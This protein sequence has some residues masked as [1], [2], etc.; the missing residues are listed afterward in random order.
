MEL[1]QAVMKRIRPVVLAAA[2]SAAL[3]TLAPAGAGAAES[4]V[5]LIVHKSNPL[6]NLTSAELRRIFLG[7]QTRWPSKAEITIL[8]P[9]PGNE[10]RKFF[11]DSL[12]KMSDDDYIRYWVSRVM[13]GEAT[14]GPRPLSPASMAR[15]VAGL[16]AAI[17]VI[18]MAD[19]PIE[20]TDLKIL[21]IDG[22]APGERG[23]RFRRKAR[24]AR[25]GK[26]V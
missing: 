6:N 23:Y 16:P 4:D 10:E 9:P 7:S 19:V 3:A 26:H 24:S 22:K 14:A 13:Q 20:E 25:P 2:L 12:L 21:R 17:G 8:L 1:A 5:A 18:G 15:L 11:L